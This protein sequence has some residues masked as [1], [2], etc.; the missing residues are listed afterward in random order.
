[1]KIK[2]RRFGEI[3]IDDAKIINMPVGLA[4]FP[5]KQRFVLLEREDIRP[6]CWYQCVEDPDLALIVMNPYVFMPDYAV[7]TIPLQKEMSWDKAGKEDMALY[8]V[9]NIEEGEKRKITA[10]LIGPLVINTRAKEAVQMVVHDSPYSHR[11]LVA[12]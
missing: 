6:F 4:G 11:H 1:M 5:G 10:N 12:G 3:D 7:D 2:T 9:V 8:V